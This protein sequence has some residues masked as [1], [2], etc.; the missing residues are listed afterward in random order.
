MR[1]ERP[2]RQR[3][4]YSVVKAPEGFFVTLDKLEVEAAC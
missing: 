4:R 3:Y 2:D 1:P